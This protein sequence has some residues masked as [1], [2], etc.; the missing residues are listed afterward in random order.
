MNHHH[1]NRAL[2]QGEMEARR[3]RAVP[4]FKKGWPLRRIG[5][6]LGVSPIA[7]HQW[8]AAWRTKGRAGLAAGRYGPAPKL[9]APK[10]KEVSRNIL[11][12]AEAHGFPGDFWTLSRLTSAVQR[13]TGVSY[14]E[15]S[16]W[17]VLKRLGFSCQK[18]VKRAV[19]RDEQSIKTWLSTTWPAVKKG[20]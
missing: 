19:E 6:K 1:P 3:L 17:H 5:A 9:P 18:P 2:S 15:R 12:G 11:R 10:E 4:Y 7:V 20:V 13:W 16:V 8:K 14:R